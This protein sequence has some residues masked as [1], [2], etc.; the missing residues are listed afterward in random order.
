M[1]RGARVPS[2]YLFGEPHKN[3]AEGFVHVENLDDR[4]RPSEWSITPH[5][6]RQLNHIFFIAGGG[7]SVQAEERRISISAPCLIIVPATIVHGF[8]W[9]AESTGSVLTL[10][11]SYLADLVRRDP[12][13][14]ALFHQ[15]KVIPLM[16]DEAA[17]VEARIS[18]LMR[19]FSWAA[20]GHRTAVDAALLPII[21]GALRQLTP[22]AGKQDLRTGHY[23]GIVARFRERVDLRFRLREPVNAHSAAIGVSNTALRVA[24]A[25]IAGTPPALILD[26]R[27][28]LEA[29][30][31]L[32]YTNLTVS[33]VAYSVGFSD[34]AY[35]T[36]FFKRHVG[37][38]PQ[39]FR[40]Q[41]IS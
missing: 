22:G 6:H 34:P 19:E 2:F 29:K 9:L 27:A 25:R 3:A 24:C 10:A 21:L 12:D 17:Q 16:P 13:V 31:T 18:E 35:F 5:S 32:L 39:A 23:T 11:N 4:S 36:R 41:R 40:L 7:G 38:S 28:L 30:R 14:A 20:L 1:I 8:H 33:E 26:E 37:C 15:P